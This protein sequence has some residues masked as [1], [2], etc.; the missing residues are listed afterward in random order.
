MTI[1]KRFARRS[2]IAA[3]MAAGL[4]AIAGVPAKAQV[5][6]IRFAKGFGIPYL[7]VI[8]LEEN[9]LV[10]KHTKALGLPEAK[11]EFMQLA[12]GAAMTDALLSGNLEYATGGPGPLL[13]VWDK[14]KGNLNVKGISAISSIPIY[15]NTINPD[16][17][18]I[19]DF[20]DKDRIAVPTVKVST[21]AVTLQM[22]A[23]QVFGKG[24]HDVLD[25]LT[26]S[27]APPDAHNAM[28]SKG[29]EITANF[30]SP[31]FM[32]LQL[33]N[34]HARRILSSYDVLGG[35]ANFI[36]MWTTARFHDANPKHHQAVLNALEEANKYIKENPRGAAEAFIKNQ[37]SP[38]QLDFVEEMVRNPEN[39]FSTAPQGV[40]KYADFMNRIGSIK[41]RPEKW[42]DMFFPAVHDRKGT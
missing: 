9:K 2:V 27:M 19:K 34:N 5:S 10:E 4:V 1:H 6:E 40:M 38:L 15:L 29:T 7:P 31:P 23:E 12:S 32:Y 26:V 8:I 25:R 22:A 11:G 42:Q 14:T 20:T 35:P 39:I 21:Q 3:G 13:T 17:K 18:T 28:M 33:R 16:V 30:T 24:K 37:K 36:L 41:N